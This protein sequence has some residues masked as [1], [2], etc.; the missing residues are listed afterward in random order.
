MQA[1]IRSWKSIVTGGA[2]AAA[3][4]IAVGTLSPALAQNEGS[5]GSASDAQVMV[6]TFNQQ[7]VIQPYQQHLQQRMMKIRKEI[8]SQG[9]G[10][11]QQQ[12]RQQMMQAQKKMKKEQQ[13]IQKRYQ[14]D[15]K[16]IMPQVAENAN[17]ELIVPSVTYK[18]DKVGTKDVT[19]QVRKRLKKVAPKTQTPSPQGLPGAPGQGGQGGQGQGQG[20]DQGQGGGNAGQ[21]QGQ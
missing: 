12:R 19:Q 16:K 8:Q 17:V 3:L 20:G 9:Q 2:A 13:K 1:F 10:Q 18:T 7:Q 11:N 6:G 21:G 14:A 4:A 15:L 5:S